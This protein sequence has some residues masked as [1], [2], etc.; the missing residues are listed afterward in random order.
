MSVKNFIPQ[1]W[2]RSIFKTYDKA[3]E[4]AAL[5]NRQYQGDIAQ[6]GD[7]V[8]INEIGDVSTNAYS[9]TVSYEDPEDASKFLIIDQQQFSGVQMD[10]IDAAQVNPA[11]VKEVTRKMGVSMADTVDQYIA[12]LYTDAGISN[13]T[14]GLTTGVCALQSTEIVEYLSYVGQLMDENNNPKQGRVAIVPPWF[15]HKMTLAKITKDTN[16]SATITEGYAGRMLGWD[17]YMSNNTPHSSTT[18]YAPMFFI[19]NDTIAFAEQIVQTEALRDIASFK[20]YLRALMVYG[21]KVVRP[22]SLAVGYVS[23][24][25]ESE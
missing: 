10:D 11:I 17:V 25:S 14:L 12:S 13:A 5:T 1:I 4:Y 21:A 7:R 15:L 18:W 23:N 20:D 16:N 3:F 8:K 22:S 19:K 9:G 24:Q 2:S 6:F